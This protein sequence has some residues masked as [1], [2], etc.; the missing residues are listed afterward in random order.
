MI[1]KPLILLLSCFICL[2]TGCTTDN[3]EYENNSN[4]TSDYDLQN[5][6]QNDVSDEAPEIVDGEFYRKAIDDERWSLSSETESQIIWTSSEDEEFV[7]DISD[8]SHPSLWAYFKE[9]LDVKMKEL[10]IDGYKTQTFSGI[11]TYVLY[12]TEK[13]MKVAQ[14]F[15]IH[16]GKEIR[17]T[18]SALKSTYN[19]NYKN[20]KLNMR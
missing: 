2:C 1:R 5:D 16:E 13:K 10:N 3:N 8:A 11:R 12:F 6:L 4:M 14:I 15:A 17:I 20:L 19:D 9:E 7:V 18:Y